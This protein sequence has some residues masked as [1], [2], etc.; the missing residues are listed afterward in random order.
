MARQ[1]KQGK[2]K[3]CN[4][5]FFLNKYESQGKRTVCLRL[6]IEDQNPCEIGVKFNG[7]KISIAKNHFDNGRII[8][9]FEYKELFNLNIFLLQLCNRAVSIGD[10]FFTRSEKINA[11]KF[12]RYLYGIAKDSAIEQPT[13]KGLKIHF[14]DQNNKETNLIRISENDLNQFNAEKASGKFKEGFDEVD[15]MVNIKVVNDIGRKLKAHK[16]LIASLPPEQRFNDRSHAFTDN[17][18]I[19]IL[20]PEIKSKSNSRNWNDQNIFDCFSYIHFG[21]RID[22]MGEEQP[23]IPKVF[24]TLYKKLLFYKVNASLVEDI[25][26]LNEDWIHE[27]YRFIYF[28]GFERRL[29]HAPIDPNGDLSIYK[30]KEDSILEKYNINTFGQAI[31]KHTKA[32]ITAMYKA[33]LIKEDFTK[34]IDA[35]AFTKNYNRNLSSYGESIYNLTINEFLKIVKAK[36]K[37]GSNEDKIRDAFVVAVML[38]GVRYKNQK[39]EKVIQQLDHF[40]MV[41]FKQAKTKTLLN[42]VMI[43]P[44]KQILKK[45]NGSLPPIPTPDAY[46]IRIRKVAKDL[47][48]DRIIEKPIKKLTGETVEQ[49]KLYDLISSK[50]ARSTYYLLGGVMGLSLEHLAKNAGHNSTDIAMKHYFQLANNYTEKDLQ[51][52]LTLFK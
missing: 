38:G 22:A 11:D 6:K 18:Y 36:L 12:Y 30:I 40:S 39:E 21:T 31:H 37:K 41:R 20:N 48:L 14:V 50:F 19:E 25:N 16:Q 35:L 10:L 26:Y 5:F 43:E 8:G 23:L 7:K 1:V 44:V 46:T 4:A 3:N 42:N 2:G 52:L 9:G 45:Y 34:K 27:F 51:E 29:H 49:V 32:F 24:K 28:T 17:S 47:G 33:N 13:D 15:E